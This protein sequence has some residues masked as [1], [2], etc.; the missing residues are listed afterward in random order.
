MQSVMKYNYVADFSRHFNNMRSYVM[1]DESGLLMASW[2][3]G[4]LKVPF[5]YFAETMTGFEYSAA[6]EMAYEGMESDAL[7]CVTSI[8][9]RFDGAK[10][11]PF[12]EPECG[13]HYARS[14]ASWALLLAWS[15]F[16]YSAVEKTMKFTSRPGRYF[17]SNGYAYGVC[18]VGGTEVSLTLL[19][20]HL[21]LDRLT[22]TG[23][24]SP[25]AKKIALKEGESV[26]FKL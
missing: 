18:E 20:G 17:W 23:K 16:H 14:M 26:R 10:R 5:P 7:K 9:N 15:D 12:D 25:V 19:G 13:R 21:D 1:G 3:K 6:V 11:S 4:R 2:P 22:L 24:K 8:R